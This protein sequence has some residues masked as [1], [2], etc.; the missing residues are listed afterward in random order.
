MKYRFA[1]MADNDNGFVMVVALQI[2]LIL[3]IIGVAAVMTTNIELQIVGNEKNARQAFY[4]AESGWQRAFQVVENSGDKALDYINP[5][6]FADDRVAV[7]VDQP[8]AGGSLYSYQ[9][10]RGAPSKA[11][12]SGKD[13]LKFNYQV[14]SVAT[15]VNDATIEIEVLIDKV[16]R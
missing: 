7:V 3:M 5:L 15:G 12:G 9:V 13:Y 1:F 4:V 8:L 14:N 6:D 2:L 11:P 16:S 10:N